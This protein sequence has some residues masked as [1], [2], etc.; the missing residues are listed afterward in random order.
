VGTPFLK[1]KIPDLLLL[2]RLPVVLAQVRVYWVLVS[3]LASIL[4]AF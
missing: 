2:L 1:V 3:L 4:L